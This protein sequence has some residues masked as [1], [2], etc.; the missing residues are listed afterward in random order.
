MRKSISLAAFLSAMFFLL[1]AANL[2][3]VQTASWEIND[4]GDW[5]KGEME[6]AVLSPDG[7]LTMGATA[8]KI[9]LVNAPITD[10]DTGLW[11]NVRIKDKTFF[12]SAKGIVYSLN[13][14]ENKL[15]EVFNTQEWLVT[16]MVNHKNNIFA[17]TIPNGKIFKIDKSGKG[18]LFATLPAGG[19]YIWQLCLDSDNVLYAATGPEG[20]IYKID[21]TGKAEVFYD[22]KKKNVLSLIF[23]G[24][25]YFYAGTAEPG[26]VYRISLKGRPE[27][28]AD[29]GELEIKTLLYYKEELFIGTNK[30]VKVAPQEFLGLIKGSAKKAEQLPTPGQGQTPKTI[31]P[32]KQQ[33]VPSDEKSPDKKQPTP[34]PDKKSSEQ[35]PDRKSTFSGQGEEQEETDRLKKSSVIVIEDGDDKTLI[36][37]PQPISDDDNEGEE[38]PTPPPPIAESKTSVSSAEI[39]SAPPPETPRPPVYCIIYK[40]TNNGLIKEFVA[41]NDCYITDMKMDK[42]GS[43][44]VGTDNSGRVYQVSQD[45]K[46]FIPCDFDAGQVLTLVMNDDDELYAVGTGKKAYVYLIQKDLARKASFTSDVRDAKFPARWGNFSFK[47]QG[48]IMLQTQS[49]NTVKPDET[50]SDWSLEIT[51]KA[52]DSIRPASPVG[53]YFRLKIFWEDKDTIVQHITQSYLIHNQQPKILEFKINPIPPLPPTGIPPRITARKIA[54][55]AKDPDNDA[56]SYRIYYRN[57]NQKVWILLNQEQPG[58]LITINDYNWNIDSLSDGRYFIRLEATDERVNPQGAELKDEKIS[59]AVIVDNTKPIIKELAV[60]GKLECSGKAEDN[61]NQI[62]RMEYSIDGGKWALVFP[63]DGIMDS[64]EEGFKFILPVTV[65]GNHNIS[66]RAFDAYGNIGMEQIEFAAH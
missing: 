24:K 32:D 44:I 4:S 37:E 15:E 39:V 55:Q 16:S 11:C 14:K 8:T 19:K 43:L 3:A 60:S 26:I 28:V 41:L 58:G 33:P 42:N 48:S 63:M 36:E 53:R 40:L 20:K 7:F 21:K 38:E 9:A 52:D 34:P 10:E 50:W 47:G 22:T 56:L 18:S 54:Y 31:T 35:T 29:F 6:G 59:E 45:G 13:T 2:Y 5:R 23:D 65:T 62:K 57:E 27:I 66:I 64:K 51:L 1:V 61:L 17:G 49:G 25:S 12:G 30:G 46:F